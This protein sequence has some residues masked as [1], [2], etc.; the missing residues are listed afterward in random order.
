MEAVD[1]NLRLKYLFVSQANV[2]KNQSG[3]FFA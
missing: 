3:I 1:I 2:F